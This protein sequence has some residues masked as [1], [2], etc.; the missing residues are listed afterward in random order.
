LVDVIEEGDVRPHSI[1]RLLIGLLLIF[2]LIFF[3]GCSAHNLSWQ[4]ATEE[5]R[6]GITTSDLKGDV[7]IIGGGLDGP[8][9][10]EGDAQWTVKTDASQINKLSM[11]I[12]TNGARHW[13]KGIHSTKQNGAV[14]ILI[15]NVLVHQII[16]DVQGEKNDYWPKSAPVGSSYYQTGSVDVS[17]KN[18]K[19]PKVDIR[20]VA[21][22][23]AVLDVNSIKLSI[24]P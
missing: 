15:N 11:T 19:G 13:G 8:S 16:C 2:L 6:N 21:N 24:S 12:Y 1:V 14:D 18:I 23:G 17:G 9:G 20:I 10:S 4:Q 22:P 5:N 3:A 7:L